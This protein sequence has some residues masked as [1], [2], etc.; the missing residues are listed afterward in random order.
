MH[1]RTYRLYT[2][3]YCIQWPEFTDSGQYRTV[4]YCTVLYCTQW[5]ECTDCSANLRNQAI[6]KNFRGAAVAGWLYCVTGQVV[7][8]TSVGTVVLVL[9]LGY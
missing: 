2:V 3:L 9:V 4:L 1:S 8:G 6:C 5:P 7:V